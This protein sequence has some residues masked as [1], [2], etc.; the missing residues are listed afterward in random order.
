MIRFKGRAMAAAMR[1]GSTDCQAFSV[2][3]THWLTVLLLPNYFWQITCVIAAS[4]AFRD[5]VH[6]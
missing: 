2:D 3:L 6:I 4:A 5:S 1:E